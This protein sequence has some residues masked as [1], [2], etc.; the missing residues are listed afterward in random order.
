MNES[1][2]IG[3]AIEVLMQ[4]AFLSHDF[5]M[6]CELV[7]PKVERPLTYIE[8]LEKELRDVMSIWDK[9]DSMSEDDREYELSPSRCE[10]RQRMIG[11]LD[12][13]ISNWYIRNDY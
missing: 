4:A 13:Q 7:A 3:R 9:L 11:Y 10:S 12:S 5:A 8:E 2:R 6:E 1:T